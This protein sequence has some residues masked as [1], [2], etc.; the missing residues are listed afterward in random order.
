M[1]H[2]S[3]WFAQKLGLVENSVPSWPWT[4]SQ[5]SNC[6]SFY[7]SCIIIV[8][9]ITCKVSNAEF[10]QLCKHWKQHIIMT[11]AFNAWQK[12]DVGAS[13]HCMMVCT[14]CGF[15]VNCLV[16]L[17]WWQAWIAVLCIAVKVPYLIWSTC[18][19]MSV[20]VTLLRCTTV[21]NWITE[22]VS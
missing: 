10:V 1:Q 3:N 19:N 5:S 13:I 12:M 16:W 2:F 9:R 4:H 7:A 21:C 18:R 17:G 8:V 22:Q 15:C 14:T 11:I 20:T 6:V